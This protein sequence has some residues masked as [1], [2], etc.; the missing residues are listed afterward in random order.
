M[1]RSQADTITKQGYL[2]KGP[3]TASD[4][5]FAHI[6]SK[7]FKRRFVLWNVLID[8]W[9]FVWCECS[10]FNTPHFSNHTS[11][12]RYCYL[13]QEVDGTYILELHKDEKQCE[14][15][16]TIVMD[17]CT[18]VVQVRQI[19]FE[20]LISTMIL[21]IVVLVQWVFNLCF[22]LRNFCRIQNEVD[23]VLSFV[24]LPAIS[25]SHWPLTMKTICAI[26]YPSCN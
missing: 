25:H 26:G 10:R 4:R 7:S 5:M 9:F 20:W 6:G 11:I 18:E 14:A 13:R 1:T 8:F 2:Y 12:Y 17:F 19:T 15:K 21:Q 22:Y 23:F 3:D 24:W 16:A